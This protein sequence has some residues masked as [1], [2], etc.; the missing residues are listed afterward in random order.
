MKYFGKREEL[1]I[2]TIN[3]FRPK[4]NCEGTPTMIL[5]EE[6]YEGFKF[7][8]WECFNETFVTVPGG[9]ECL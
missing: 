3:Q 7:I 4:C 1:K 2:E 8:C 5:E 6:T 9:L